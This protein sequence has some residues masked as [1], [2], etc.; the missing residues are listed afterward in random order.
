MRSGGLIDA[1]L[2]LDGSFFLT[3]HRHATRE[4]M[5][6]AYPRLPEFLE[7]KRRCDPEGRFVSDWFRHLLAVVG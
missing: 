7:R 4:Q 2:D 1:A 6:R 3:Y 5:L